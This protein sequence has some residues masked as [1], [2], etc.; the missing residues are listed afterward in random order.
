[1]GVLGPGRLGLFRQGGSLVFRAQADAVMNDGIIEFPD[2]NRSVRGAFRDQDHGRLVEHVLFTLF[3]EL[4]RYFRA[5]FQ[6]VAV[7]VA[8]ENQ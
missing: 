3:A 8:D 6:D 7:F 1:M 5:Q 2:L 4:H